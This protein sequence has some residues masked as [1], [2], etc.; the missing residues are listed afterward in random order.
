MPSFSGWVPDTRRRSCGR[1]L[2]CG[3]PDRHNCAG[4]RARAPSLWTA[5]AASIGRESISVEVEELVVA[6]VPRRGPLARAAGAPVR[7]R[8]R[9]RRGHRA[10]GVPA[11]RPPRRQDRRASTGRRPT[12]DRSCSTSPATTTGAAS[13]RS[14]TTR[15]RGREV[16]VD[17]DDT[18]GDQLV[19]SEEHGG[20]STR[21]AGSRRASAT[22]SR[23][24]TSRSCSI[25]AIAST[26]GALGELGEDASPA[27]DGRARPIAGRVDEQRRR[28]NNA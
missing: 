4:T 6:A 5:I 13:C 14:A 2:R 12:C 3:E 11:P 16:D 22:A 27:G 10:G 15:R 18:V 24:A 19:R 7:R 1:R 28:S 23:C 26:L 8:P 17:I 25:D 20:C 9:R 21:C